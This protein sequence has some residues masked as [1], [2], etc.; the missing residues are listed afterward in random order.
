VTRDVGNRVEHDFQ[1]DPNTKYY[2]YVGSDAVRHPLSAKFHTILTEL[3]ALHDRKQADYGRDADPF[4]NVRASAEWGLQPWV[5]AMVRL[6]DKVR[7]LQKVAQGGSLANEG[8]ID[9]LNDIAVYA[10]IAR[11]L[12]EEGHA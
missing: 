5:G 7:R 2:T 1:V 6:H 8:V 10:V 3:G 9:S 11:V 4:A 12:Y